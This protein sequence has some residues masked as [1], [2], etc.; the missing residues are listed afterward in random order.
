[1]YLQTP[2]DPEGSE[3]RTVV[4]QP[5]AGPDATS[6]KP[7]KQA[8]TDE[9][10]TNLVGVLQPNVTL[11]SPFGQ[12]VGGQRNDAAKPDT[13]FDD[14]LVDNPGPDQTTETK[15]EQLSVQGAKSLGDDPLT[16]RGQGQLSLGGRVLTTQGRVVPG[17]SIIAQAYNHNTQSLDAGKLRT[18]SAEDGLYVFEGLEAGEYQLWTEATER[19]PEVRAMFRS[20]LKSADLVLNEIFTINLVGTVTNENGQG[21]AEVT[22]IIPDRKQATQTGQEGEY[23]VPLQVQANRRYT[24]R[25]NRDG[26]HEKRVTKT[27]AE[28]TTAG[29]HRIDVQLQ[30]I[31]DT[32][33]VHGMV[34]S[35]HG[36]PLA[37][38]H[39]YL[40]SSSLN[41]RHQAKSDEA[42]NFV[43]EGVALGAD[44]QIWVSPGGLYG[45]Y[46]HGPVEIIPDTPP[47]E[48]QLPVLDGGS[49]SG[50]VVDSEGTPMSNFT[51]F[52][53]SENSART[54]RVVTDDNGQFSP[55]SLAAG[56]LMFFTQ[57]QPRHTIRGF[58]LQAGNQQ[59]AHL[60][61]DWGRHEVQGT[62]ADENGAVIA[63]VKVHMSMAYGFYDMRASSTRDTITDERGFFRFTQVGPGVH[64]IRI[65]QNRYKPYKTDYDVGGAG[66]ELQIK[67]TPK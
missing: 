38:Q 46:Q 30:R 16:N 48:I 50:Q 39:V 44:Y 4:P 47:L 15:S 66:G 8:V 54:S 22:I 56:E 55:V 36:E 31:G 1:M 35:E 14:R 2:I 45:K 53:R 19:F 11:Q 43:L 18:I 5:D 63:G 52:V 26:F 65:S 12:S 17:I 27:G 32:T 57:I 29:N 61:M 13:S 21:L 41:A 34:T 58:E 20:G 49:V 3:V 6:P 40:Q 64:V 9:G 67:L 10:E 28:L 33:D 37:G 60:Q 42:G 25:F 51:L 23:S 62:I 7:L 59:Y 24:L